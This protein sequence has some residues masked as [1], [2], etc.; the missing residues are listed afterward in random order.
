MLSARP[1]HAKSNGRTL[2]ERWF[3]LSRK[4]AH[5]YSLV[6]R[7][8]FGTDCAAIHFAQL[9]T[10]VSSGVDCVRLNLGLFW[11][12][13]LPMTTMARDAPAESQRFEL[14]GDVI[15]RLGYN[16]VYDADSPLDETNDFLALM[17]ASPEFH[18]GESVSIK[19]EIRLEDIR[20]PTKDRAFE[21]E[22]LFVRKLFSEYRVHDNLSL[23]IGKF[24]PSFSF[25]SLVTPGMYGNNYNKE[26]E[27]IERIGIGAE[28]TIDTGSAGTYRISGST[29][30][31]DTSF[32]SDSLGSSRGPKTRNDGGASNTGSL[33]S[34]TLSFEG[35]NFDRVPGFR[36]KVGL[37]HQ[38]AGRDGTSDENGFLLAAMRTYQME[39]DR[40]W[41]WIAEVAPLWN[42]EGTEDDIVYTSAGLVYASGPW[43]TVVSGTYRQRDLAAGDRYNDYSLQTSLDYQF[44]N[45]LSFAIAHEFLRSQN[46]KSRRLGLRLS[47][48]ILL[49]E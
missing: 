2:Y 47:K 19:S 16:G 22:G 39:R 33:E 17:I 3:V 25:A 38:A 46:V 12:L 20:P 49:G 4:M 10:L 21:D 5:P 44:G 37:L 45:G 9:N 26:I 8:L 43:T 7:S 1:H 30:F 48:T 6:P 29:F 31:D 27:L 15:F 14:G 36:Y 28:Y 32:L 34:F 41:T 35:L 40:S 11:A 42:Y 24:T 23:Q 18:F 13:L